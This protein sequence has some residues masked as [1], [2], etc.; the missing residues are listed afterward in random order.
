VTW[1]FSLSAFLVSLA[2]EYRKKRLLAMMLAVRLSLEEIL[3]QEWIKQRPYPIISGALQSE[4]HRHTYAILWCMKR[5]SLFLREDQIRK[6]KKWGEETEAH[7]AAVVRH[8]LDYYFLALKEGGIT[9][10]LLDGRVARSKLMN[11]RP[12]H[13]DRRV[14]PLG[15]RAKSLQQRKRNFIKSDRHSRS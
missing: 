11:P 9:P 8:A 7:L 10:K 5:I 12:R 3:R 1:I 14:K 15:E 2:L 6:A 4:G 13:I